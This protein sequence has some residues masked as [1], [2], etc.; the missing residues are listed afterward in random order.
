MWSELFS[1]SVESRGVAAVHKHV[2]ESGMGK[3]D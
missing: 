2:L 3:E 1:I